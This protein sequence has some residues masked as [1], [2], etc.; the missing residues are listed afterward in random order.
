[1]GNF[2]IVFQGE[3]VWQKKNEYL[4]KMNSRIR[5]RMKQAMKMWHSSAKTMTYFNHINNEK[6]KRLLGFVSEILKKSNHTETK[7][8]ILMFRKNSN[9][10]KIQT[11]FLNRLCDSQAGKVIKA[12]MIWKNLPVPKN[13]E[14]IAKAS[15]FESGLHHFGMKILRHSFGKFK[16]EHYFGNDRKKMAIRRLVDKSC[17]GIDK[18]FSIWKK[19]N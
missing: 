4:K 13:K 7:N 17:S 1:M 3:K 18:Y 11:K 5:D 9:V 8:A 2:E 15:R 12:M 6:K 14:L 10:T 19:N 16:D